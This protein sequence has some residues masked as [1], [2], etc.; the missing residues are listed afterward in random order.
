MRELLTD[1]GYVLFWLVAVFF[2]VV[3]ECSIVIL[4]LAVF[5]A[6]GHLLR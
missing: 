1:V 6:V 3:R 2:Y 5:L 4:L